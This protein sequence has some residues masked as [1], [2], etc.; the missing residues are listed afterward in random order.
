M[1]DLGYTHLRKHNHPR[2]IMYPKV[3]TTSLSP[4]TGGAICQ[5]QTPLKTTKDDEPAQ[6][7]ARLIRPYLRVDLGEP[8][9]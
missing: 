5:G 8:V 7:A 4:G 6:F 3:D 9:Y 2:G 1:V